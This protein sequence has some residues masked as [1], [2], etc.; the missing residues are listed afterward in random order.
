MRQKQQKKNEDSQTG[1]VRLN[2]AIIRIFYLKM[3]V[4]VALSIYVGSNDGTVAPQQRLSGRSFCCNGIFIIMFCHVN[5]RESYTFVFICVYDEAISDSNVDTD[6]CGKYSFAHSSSRKKW[7]DRDIRWM[8]GW[9]PGTRV[10]Q[11]I[12]DKEEYDRNYYAFALYIFSY[13]I[14]KQK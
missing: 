12:H 2:A 9:M 14:Y 3:I 5:N 4:V 6:R 13:F 10:R 1:W 7:R 11:Q 8:D